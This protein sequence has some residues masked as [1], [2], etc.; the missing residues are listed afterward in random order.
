MSEEWLIDGYNL[1]HDLAGRR[2]GRSGALPLAEKGA[3][4]AALAGFA[5]SG[6]RRVT[7]VL[8]GVGRDAEFGAYRT[9][10]FEVVHSQ[11]V[12][13]DTYIERRIAEQ[14]DRSR[15]VVV[16]RDR[17][18]VTFARGAGARVTDPGELLDLLKAEDR[19]HDETLFK[20]RI[21]GHGFNRPFD[22][23]LKDKGAS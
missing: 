7:V 2:R 8:D 13:A 23:K 10:V 6:S 21:A 11:K 4:F 17:A 3:L 20:H 9:A 19:A 15:I 16:T 5:A 22:R 1:L 12:S 18:I 14:K